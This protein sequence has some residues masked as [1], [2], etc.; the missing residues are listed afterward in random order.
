MSSN[1]KA[2]RKDLLDEYSGYPKVAVRLEL[3]SSEEMPHDPLIT[4][5][6]FASCEWGCE[7][8]RRSK[9]LS[10]VAPKNP[11]GKLQVLPLARNVSISN[12]HYHNLVAT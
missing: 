9:D 3:H 10:A 7:V 2:S 1:K 4:E 6:G 8:V 12:D 11:S 5:V